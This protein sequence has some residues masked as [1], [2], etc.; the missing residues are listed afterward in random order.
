MGFVTMIKERCEDGDQN[1]Y[2]NFL[3]ILQD[4][5]QQTKDLETII[6]EVFAVSAPQ[7]LDRG[8]LQRS[9]RHH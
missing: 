6:N 2:K 8:P 4:F 9:R 5:Q 3:N 1:T 7:S